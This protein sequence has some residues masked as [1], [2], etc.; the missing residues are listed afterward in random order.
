MP[1]ESRGGS[2]ELIRLVEQ[3]RG[4]LDQ[5]L[6]LAKKGDPV[7]APRKTPTQKPSAHKRTDADFTTP[8]R[9]FVK[10]FSP[11]MNGARKFTLLVAYMAQ[12][13]DTKRV[14]LGDVEKK[15]NSMKASNLLGMKF[16]RRYSSQAKENDWVNTEKTGVYYLRPS[17]KEIFE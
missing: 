4:L 7:K 17:W 1:R 16:N 3:A 13:D 11:G 15:W 6:A 9:A 14:A 2:S 5:A 10:R 8:I 12:G